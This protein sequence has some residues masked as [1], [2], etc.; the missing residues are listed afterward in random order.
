MAAILGDAQH[1]AGVGRGLDHPTRLGNRVRDRLLHRHVLSGAQRRD[2]VLGVEWRRAEH[3][4]RIDVV[5]G[6]ERVDLGVAAFY[7][8]FAATP[9]EDLRPRVAQRDDVARLMG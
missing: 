6:Q 2:R 9:L 5:V 4:H 1:L 8:P 3:L 7:P